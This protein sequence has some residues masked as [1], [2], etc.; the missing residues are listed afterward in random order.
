MKKNNIALIGMPTSGKSFLGKKLSNQIGYNFIDFDVEIAKIYGEK[1]HLKDGE[2]AFLMH[3]EKTILKASGE[4]NIFSCGGSSVY[5]DKAMRYLKGLSTVIYL[6]VSV[7]VLENRIVDYIDRGVIGARQKVLKDLLAERD[8]LYLK[9]SDFTVS[10][11]NN[12][13]D[14]QYNKLVKVCDKV[15]EF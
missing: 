15:L 13:L 1:S 4:K 5:S 8:P 12:N 7:N 2:K 6:K 11:S 9:Y 3:E 14:E 10:V